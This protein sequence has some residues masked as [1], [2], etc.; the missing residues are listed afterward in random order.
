MAFTIRPGRR[1]VTQVKAL[2]HTRTPDSMDSMEDHL[3][4]LESIEKGFIIREEAP[5][6]PHSY[7]SLP[8][9]MQFPNMKSVEPLS[10]VLEPVVVS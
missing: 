6:S 4:T 1:R 8:S 3:E 10:R 7:L 2:N 5:V 9:C